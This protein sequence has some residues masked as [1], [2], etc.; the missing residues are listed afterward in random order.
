MMT[1]TRDSSHSSS[2]MAL[3]EILYV[4]SKLN[5]LSSKMK[6]SL[7]NLSLFHIMP[8]GLSVFPGAGL[9]VLDSENAI[10]D[11]LT[12]TWELP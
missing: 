11:S 4:F 2:R 12:E 1:P 7:S 9:R 10:W 3:L 6:T 5:S 8:G